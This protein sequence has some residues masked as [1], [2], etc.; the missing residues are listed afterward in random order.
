M[1]GEAVVGDCG[2]LLY[3]GS[4]RALAAAILIKVIVLSEA[5]AAWRLRELCLIMLCVSRAQASEKDTCHHC[6]V[7]PP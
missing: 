3:S 6:I 4:V 7:V 1:R 5:P 2:G